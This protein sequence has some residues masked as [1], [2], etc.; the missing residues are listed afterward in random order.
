MLVTIIIDYNVNILYKRYTLYFSLDAVKQLRDQI[1][2]LN[3]CVILLLILE[4]KV[5][6]YLVEQQL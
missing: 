3:F 4:I 1:I 6:I 2:A 5:H